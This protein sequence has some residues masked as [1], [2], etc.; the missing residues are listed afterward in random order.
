[1]RKGILTVAAACTVL[2]AGAAAAGDVLKPT[3]IDVGKWAEGIAY[4]GHFLWVAESGQRRIAKIDLG[5]GTVVQR[6][7]VGRLPVDMATT[8]DGTVFAMVNTDKLIYRPSGG[9]HV[10]ARLGECPDAMIADGL[11]LWALTEPECSSVSSRLVKVDSRSGAQTR[12]RVLAEWATALTAEG[13]D[14]WVAHARGPALTVVDKNTLAPQP[15]EV[16]GA[17]LWA[18]TALGGKVYGGGRLGEDNAAGLVVAIDA[19]TRRELHRAQVPERVA[20]ITGDGKYVLAIGEKGT[21]WVFAADDLTL[22][23]TVTLS[24]GE[25]Q[26]RG[27]LIRGDDVLITN[28]MQKGENGAVLVVSGWRP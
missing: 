3:V 1:M 24:T 22:L 13:G 16:A 11:T 2:F 9:R 7:T 20:E 18:V 5:A 6:V 25:F 17:S 23:R 4:D 14:I 12:S 15:L 21:L 10:L 26:P 27:V 8:A 28:L 19:R